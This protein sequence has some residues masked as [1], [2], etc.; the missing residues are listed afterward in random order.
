MISYRNSNTREEIRGKEMAESVE[1]KTP[2][3]A[4]EILV[5]KVIKIEIE[6]NT[7]LYRNF[8]FL[9]ISSFYLDASSIMC[10][11]ALVSH[12]EFL[13]SLSSDSMIFLLGHMQIPMAHIFSSQ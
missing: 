10:W 2:G 7:P 11:I 3:A 6:R 4:S 5:Y 1:T 9:G 8:D 13:T 12:T